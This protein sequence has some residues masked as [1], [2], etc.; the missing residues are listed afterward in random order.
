M[1]FLVTGADGYVGRHVVTALL[2]MGHAVTVPVRAGRAYERRGVS[3]VECDILAAEEGIFQQLGRP[4]VCIHLAW[5]HGFVHNSPVH[6]ENVSLHMN[7]IKHMLQGGLK[8]IVGVGT[9]HEIGPYLGAEPWRRS[10]ATSKI[11][12]RDTLTSLSWAAGSVWKWSPR[13]TP[14]S[15]DSE[16][17]SCTKST[18]MPASCRLALL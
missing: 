14:R 5:Q 3:S 8:H 1:K 2:E 13:T 18:A 16:K 4:D 15:R 11:E 6:L 12:P 10:T 7:F 9:A 17:L